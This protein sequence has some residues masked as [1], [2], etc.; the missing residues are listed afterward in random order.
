MY[1]LIF[2]KNKLFPGSLDIDFSSFP[3]K[4][5]LAIHQ[6]D[7]K[8]HFSQRN[9]A[10]K[11]GGPNSGQLLVAMYAWDGNAYPGNEYWTGQLTASGDPA[12]A[13]CSTYCGV[14]KSS[15]QYQFDLKQP[16]S[17]RLLKLHCYLNFWYRYNSMSDAGTPHK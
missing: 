15:H 12:A 7:I 14:T 2:Y 16:T 3:P 10:D 1:M 8:I 9:P 5:T 4:S 6:K 13:C 11:L 17:S